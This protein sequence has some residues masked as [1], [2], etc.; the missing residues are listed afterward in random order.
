MELQSAMKKM[1][2]SELRSFQKKMLDK[3]L[4]MTD[5]LCIVPTSQGKSLVFQLLALILEKLVIVVEPH[6]A[7]ELDQVIKLQKQGIP[8]AYIN[9]M[10]PSS[11]RAK[12]MKQIQQGSLLLVYMTPEMLQNKNIKSVLSS[13]DIGGIMVDEAHCIVK[14]GPGFREDYLKIHEVIKGLSH[15][16]V[17]ELLLRLLPAKLKNRL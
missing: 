6:L 13:C 14:Q 8:S 12:I 17:V 16:P 3:L 1:G 5:V 15:R 10:I 2:V 4:N 9:S 7:L 11:E